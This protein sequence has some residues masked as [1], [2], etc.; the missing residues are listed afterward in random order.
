MS[1]EQELWNS[2]SNMRWLNNIIAAERNYRI[3]LTG[4]HDHNAA[5]VVAM[6]LGRDP[7]VE[8]LQLSCGPDCGPAA[9]E[10]VALVVS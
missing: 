3:F 4:S 6:Q 8:A 10:V 7:L 9:H 1:N 2:T 5:L